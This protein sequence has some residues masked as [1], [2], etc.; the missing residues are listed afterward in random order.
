MEAQIFVF[1]MMAGLKSR[2]QPRDCVLLCGYF[3]TQE[4]C[5]TDTP[6]FYNE[7][8]SGKCLN[9]QFAEWKEGN[10]VTD[11]LHLNGRWEILHA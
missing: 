5:L 9:E 6:H 4:R 11:W 2:S 7:S 10:E 3:S 8:T 1:I